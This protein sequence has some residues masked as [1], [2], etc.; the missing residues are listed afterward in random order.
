MA[1]GPPPPPPPAAPGPS[2]EVYPRATTNHAPGMLPPAGAGPAAAAAAGA[3]IYH[4]ITSTS[5][6]KNNDYLCPICFE[7][8]QE[9]YV[10]RCGHTFCHGC[11]V[12]SLSQSARCPKCNYHMEKPLESIF[13]NFAVDE[14]VS[15]YSSRR[16]AV[17]EHLQKPQFD[18]L[19][20]SLLESS[21]LMSVA[22]VD[23][24]LRFLAQRKEEIESESFLTQ[25][26]LL[27]DFL[28]H[29]KRLKDDQLYQLQKQTAV[30]SSDLDLVKAKIDDFVSE[31][32]AA[33]GGA[34]LHIADDPSR[35]LDSPPSLKRRRGGGGG[36]D[37]VVPSSAALSAMGECNT[38]AA[39]AVAGAANHSPPPLPYLMTAPLS[40]T[41]VKR[42]QRMHAH[43]DD[44]ANCYFSTRAKEMIFP[45]TVPEV[46][47]GGG[48]SSVKPSPT[49]PP[50]T[51]LS[52][53][54][55]IACG[56]D[57]VGSLDLFSQ[58]LSKFTRYS[59][60]RPLA[61]L[62]YT[63]DMFTNASIVSS[64][65]FDKDNEFFAIAGISKRIKIYEYNVV[66]KDVVDIHYP[67]SE[68]ICA[69]KTSCV[70]WS[71]FHKNN[72]VSSDYEGTVTVWD[73]NTREKVKTFQEHEKRCW[74]VDFNL[75]DTNLIASGSDDARVKLWSTNV[76]HSVASLE[77]KANICCVKFNP[78]SCY[79]LA[80]GSADHCVHYYDLRN[81]KEA[82]KMFKGHKKAVSYVKFLNGSDLVSASTDSQLKLWDVN[83]DTCQRSFQGH[84]NEKNFV[85]LATDGDYVT[86]GSEN[87]SLFVYYKGL[88]KPLFHYKFDMARGFF[89]RDNRRSA[90]AAADDE[91]NEFVSAVC[92]RKNTNVL[93]G[94]NSQGTI[95]ILEM[96]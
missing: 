6:D 21:S 25:Q 37:G 28:V 22:D 40:N 55:D 14:L 49:P 34:S 24:L 32:G 7:F 90:A 50:S 66:I 48:E 77:A 43:F 74:S 17:K 88:S 4:G 5:M 35:T 83:G 39:A 95:K 69:S 71:H 31:K 9:A 67:T 12:K 68:M 54:V 44:L 20:M 27:R 72:L 80:F 26:L 64:I 94:A 2:A 46:G 81:T 41:L 58:C 30:I 47:A 86:C 62:S 96:V 59:T 36:A 56:D 33:A 45:E 87:N 10:T 92:W 61:N 15:R 85:G 3:G 78:A 16:K 11:I 63:S 73:T 60:V 84:V 23:Y 29:L 8:L 91:S 13:P 93:V 70:A 19:K 89:D 76:N 65:E 75:V 82:L 79:H 18:Q 52:E 42:K 51:S 1:T 57:G 38:A 53:R